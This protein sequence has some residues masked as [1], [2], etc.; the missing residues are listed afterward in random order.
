MSSEN[1]IES[2][3]E[4]V[5][6]EKRNNTPIPPTEKTDLLS[7]SIDIELSEVENKKDVVDVPV[8]KQSNYIS[9]EIEPT[10]EIEVKIAEAEEMIRDKPVEA[11]V[12]EPERK[13]KYIIL[14][15][16]LSKLL[17]CK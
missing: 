4:K 11:S 2:I 1:L 6:D 16:S 10:G 5:V 7:E 3:F 8:S 9:P 15:T 13:S 14:C 12:V 17:C